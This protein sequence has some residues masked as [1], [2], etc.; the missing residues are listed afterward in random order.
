MLTKEDRSKPY[1]KP[2][3][4]T[5]TFIFP[6]NSP[7][8]SVSFLFS[9]SVALLRVLHMAHDSGEAEEVSHNSVPFP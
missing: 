7:C 4:S 8:K 1:L 5:L 2:T 6:K 3:L 9:N